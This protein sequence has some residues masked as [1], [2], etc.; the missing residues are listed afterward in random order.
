[1]L[2]VISVC[3]VGFI[4]LLLMMIGLWG[5]LRMFCVCMGWC[6]SLSGCCLGLSI[7]MWFCLLVMW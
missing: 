7:G 5:D 1:M 6:L 4:M 2:V 3:R